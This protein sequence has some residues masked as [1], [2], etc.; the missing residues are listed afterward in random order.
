MRILLVGEHALLLQG[1]MKLLEDEVAAE[2]RTVRRLP[3]VEA[4]IAQWQPALAILETTQ[5]ESIQDLTSLL[6]SLDYDVPLLVIAP[7]EREPFLAAL[8]A[9]ARGFVGRHVNVEELLGA[10]QAV[11]RGEWG[12]PRSLVGYLVNE[13]LLLVRE[14]P[15][16]AQPAFSERE[17]RVLTLLARGMNARRIG[18]LL[19]V[20]SSTVRGEIRAIVQKLGVENRTQAVAEA[21]RRGLLPT[22][23]S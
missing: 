21:L 3:D 14:Q 20:S 9:G 16:P 6:A 8:R 12:I 15:A 4:T 10:I 13:Y 23:E 18:E 11:Q 5:T 22:E 17:R 7:S 1:L 2:V 19:F